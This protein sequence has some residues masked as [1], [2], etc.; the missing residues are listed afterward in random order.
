MLTLAPWEGVSDAGSGTHS[1]ARVVTWLARLPTANAA[2]RRLPSNDGST[3]GP[4]AVTVPTHSP[5]KGTWAASSR[6]NWR[7]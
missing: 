3:P 6:P 2:N 1:S 4:T 7:L 5:P